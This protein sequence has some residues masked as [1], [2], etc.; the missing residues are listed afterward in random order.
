MALTVFRFRFPR[1]FFL[2]WVAFLLASQLSAETAGDSPTLLDVLDVTGRAADLVGAAESA[3]QGSVGYHELDSRPFL[4]R[5]EL[6]EV[7]PGLVV[8]Q[9]SGSGK[10][11]QYF[12]RGFNLDHGTDFAVSVDGVPVN[13]R[14]HAHGQGYSDLNFIIPEL[15]SGVTYQKGQYS[16]ANGDFSAAGAAQFHLADSLP[17]N[18]LHVEFGEN[19]YARAVVAGTQRDSSGA[20]TTAGL[21]VGYDNGP[22]L[23]AEHSRRFNLFT[24]HTW[25]SG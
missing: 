15:V 25:M 19:A 14:T 13:M 11:N 16:A 20:T 4:R 17:Q 2:A 9:H 23:S 24:R 6:L 5:G 22:W 3:S 1:P 10:A 8:T 21:E 12:L 18:L 7:I